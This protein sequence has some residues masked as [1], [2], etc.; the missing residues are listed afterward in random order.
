MTVFLKIINKTQKKQPVAAV[1]DNH[2]LFPMNL[3]AGSN[4]KRKGKHFFN[5]EKK[6]RKK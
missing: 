3:N 2:N 6:G 1:A 4:K 5:R